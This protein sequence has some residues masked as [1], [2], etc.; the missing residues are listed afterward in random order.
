MYFLFTSSRTFISPVS[1]SKYLEQYF[2]AF[3]AP[4]FENNLKFVGK[5][6]FLIK[7]VILFRLESKGN[8]LKLFG[9][10]KYL[11][12]STLIGDLNRYKKSINALSVLFLVSATSVSPLILGL[13]NFVIEHSTFN[14]SAVFKISQNFSFLNTV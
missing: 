5:P 13:S 1:G 2:V 14:A 11:S 9:D 10:D 12:C 7:V 8:C 4:P 6:S 3:S